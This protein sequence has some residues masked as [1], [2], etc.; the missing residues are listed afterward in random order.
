MSVKIDG[1]KCV[2]CAG[3]IG[4]CPVNALT[5]YE[6]KVVCD[7]KCID[8]SACIKACP[9]KAISSVKK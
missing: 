4:F 3:C 5:L 8:C 1:L 9:I 2:Y 6:T 7:E